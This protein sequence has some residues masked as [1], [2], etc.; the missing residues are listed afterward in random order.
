VMIHRA[1]MGSL[2]RFIGILI[3]HYAGQFPMWLAPEQVRVLPVTDGEAAYAERLLADLRRAG[4]RATVDLRNEKL[5]W[6]IRAAQ[7]ERVPVMLVAGRREVENGQVAVRTR[8]G[9]VGPRPWPDYLADLKEM[10]RRP[11]EADA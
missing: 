2:E 8:A 5:G 11:G 1:I 9:D 6:R 3:E 7:L 10:A 4:L